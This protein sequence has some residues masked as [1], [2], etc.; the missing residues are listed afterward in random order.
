[1]LPKTYRKV[2]AARFTNDFQEAAEIVEVPMPQPATNEILVR[3]RYAGVNATDVNISAGS[4]TPHA[5]PPLDL[6]AE[7]VG[8]VVAVG[9]DVTDLKVG[10]AVLTNSVGSGYREYQTIRAFRA[11]PVPEATP[12]VLSLGLSGATASI[13]LNVTGEMKNDETVLVTAAAGGTG[14]FAVQLAKLKGNHVIGTCSTDEKADLL[15]SLGCDRV[16]NYRKEDLGTVLRVEYPH[17]V[18]LVYESVGRGMFDT[19]VDNLAIRGR[20][21]II[22]YITEYLSTPE[23]VTEPRLYFKLLGK[24]ASIRSMFLPHFFK[25]VPEHLARL[26]EF[27]TSGTLQA[28]VDPTE[29]RGVEEV[30]DAVAYLHSGQS[31]GKVVVRF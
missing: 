13:G 11:A 2:V 29:F 23:V 16:I 4:Y 6:G 27:Y 18:N 26:M 3:N 20:L 21:V 7:A 1:M 8:E 5:Q 10:D 25:L 14:Q 22:G 19:A 24:S 30:A 9:E 28:A 17:G 15:H 12:E 31:Q